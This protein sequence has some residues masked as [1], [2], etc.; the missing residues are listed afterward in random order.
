MEDFKWGKEKKGMKFLFYCIIRKKKKTSTYV[1]I[2]VFFYF[3]IQVG[4]STF[5]LVFQKV[6]KEIQT[7]ILLQSERR[8]ANPQ[9]F[10]QNPENIF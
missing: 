10:H 5:I 6:S 1:N 2:N 3:P 8:T 9:S 7:E 4:M